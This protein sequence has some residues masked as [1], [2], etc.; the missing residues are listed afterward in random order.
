MAPTLHTNRV[1]NPEGDLVSV[2]QQQGQHQT[3]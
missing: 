2:L 1:M 3:L